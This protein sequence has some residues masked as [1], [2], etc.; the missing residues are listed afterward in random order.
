MA[1]AA[2]SA[3]LMEH[4]LWTE[5]ASSRTLLDGPKRSKIEEELADIMIYSIE[6]A[7][8]AGIDLASAIAEKMKK[9]A[10]KYPVEKARGRADKY[11]EL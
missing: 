11:D 5:A 3:E 6:F 8:V 1:I 9:N 10:A 7:N 2:E 4:F